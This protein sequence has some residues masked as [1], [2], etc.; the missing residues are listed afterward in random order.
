MRK[1][2]KVA[3]SLS[4]HLLTAI[5]KQRKARG[6]SRSEVFRKAAEK[7]LKQEQESEAIEKYFRGYCDKPES[8]TE[9]E[10]IRKTATVLLAQEPW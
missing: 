3:I 10:A 8:A 2:T 6:E 5:D 7:L 9:V 4:E 1:N